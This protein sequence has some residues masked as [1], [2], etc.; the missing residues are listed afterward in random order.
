METTDKR[1]ADKFKEQQK[2]LYKETVSQIT[3]LYDRSV[4]VLLDTTEEN[5]DWLRKAKT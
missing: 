3:E 1:T 5:A 2:K 4:S